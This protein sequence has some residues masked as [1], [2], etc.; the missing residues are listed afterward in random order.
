MPEVRHKGDAVSMNT[1]EHL[2]PYIRMSSYSQIQNEM[3]GP[4]TVMGEKTASGLKTAIRV[5]FRTIWNKV[6]SHWH[7][8]IL[9]DHWY[10]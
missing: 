9:S 2:Q 8:L 1:D 3:P 4:P 6:Y 7:Y 10:V 5:R